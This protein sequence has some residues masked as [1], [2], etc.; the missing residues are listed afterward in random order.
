MWN[1]N[2]VGGDIA[3]ASYNSRNR[4]VTDEHLTELFSIVGDRYGFSDVGA[5]FSAFT[6]FK[7]R[8][9]RSMSWIRFQVS[10]YLDRAPDDVLINLADVLFSKLRGDDREYDEAFIRYVTEKEV[11]RDNRRDFLGRS[12]NLNDTSVGKYH[13]LCDCVDRL[14]DQGLIPDDLE[15]ELRWDDTRGGKA[16]GCSV[17]QRVVW[18]SKVLDQ[19][20]IPE[21]VL[22]YSVYAMFC[23]LMIGFPG[24]RS[25]E[26]YARL[27]SYYPARAEAE[28]WMARNDL[29]L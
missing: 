19:K 24:N 8:W 15:C 5:E 10:D 4:T 12:R 23:H 25:D 6:D 29:Y 20:G 21:N 3:I 14:R 13:D 28:D 11:S 2:T 1:R 26:E 16:S 22:D 7:V 17:L 18:V 27:L 9:Q